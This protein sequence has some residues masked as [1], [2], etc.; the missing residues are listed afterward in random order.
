MMKAAI[1]TVNTVKYINK[2]EDAAAAALTRMLGKVSIET[3]FVTTL[4]CEEK[5][6]RTI[7][8]KLAENPA[9]DMVI[10]MGANGTGKKDCVPEATIAVSEQLIPGIPE[11]VRAYNLRYSKR[12]MLDRSVV[13]IA[14][15]TLIVNLPEGAKTAQDSLEFVLP[16]LIQVI[17]DME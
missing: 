13:G 10:T 16:E 11:A 6:V 3:V 14:Q 1:I 15:E 8:Q 2:T 4:P 5:V 12:A 17:D 9:I 7:L